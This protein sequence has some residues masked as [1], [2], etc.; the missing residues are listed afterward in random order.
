MLTF[1]ASKISNNIAKTPEGYLICRNVPIARTGR[2]DYYGQ[3]LG[4]TDKWDE[5]I[6]VYRLEEDVFDEKALASFEAKSV[7]D[8]HPT[9]PLSVDNV[10]QYEKGHVQNIRRDG[11]EVI[12]DLIIK[13][14]NLISQ[15]ENNIKREISC[16]YNCKYAPYK[17]G[18]RQYDICGNHVAIVT[19]GRAGSHVCIKDEKPERR[20]GIMSK[21]NKILASMLKSYARDAS[22]EELAEAMEVIGEKPETHDEEEASLLTKIKDMFTKKE[23]EEAATEDEAATEEVKD[24]APS[25][26]ER[27]AKVEEA[28]AKLTAVEKEEGHE[29]LDEEVSVVDSLKPVIAKL[30]AKDR[31]MITDALRKPVSG[32]DGYAII[33]DAM[34]S[35]VKDSIQEDAASKLGRDIAAK[36]NPHYKENK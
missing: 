4:I 25:I 18:Y 2:Q 28:L 15:V 36:F 17:D 26:E 10:P 16:G 34:L 12:G 7:T 19:K 31:K 5:L 13:D 29:S 23:A 20:I 27:L 33:Q 6:P 14:P 24:D 1:F 32:K 9:V 3:E 22:P 21:K 30:N 11:D 8:N 35:S